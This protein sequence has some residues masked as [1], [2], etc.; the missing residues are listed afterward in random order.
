MAR[1]KP[2]LIVAL[3]AL[4]AAASAQANLIVLNAADN[5]I[6]RAAVVKQGDLGGKGWTGG[7]QKPDLSPGSGCTSFH[8]KES[9]LVTTGA[10][11]TQFSNGALTFDS[12]V[13][14]LRTAAMV[15][16]DW[17]RSI[18]PATITCLKE[19]FRNGAGSRA[20]VIS[21]ARTGFPRV[22]SMTANYRIVFAVHARGQ[23]V[24]V[25]VFVDTLLLGKGRAELNLTTVSPLSAQVPVRAA[26]IRLARLIAARLKSS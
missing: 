12:E 22:T 25:R 8:P 23:A 20:A 15:R 2:L 11:A 26:E 24:P 7:S 19:L 5:A 14:V 10:A 21:A 6:A 16:T 9:D 13:Q 18:K 4:I 3:L 17:R 1:A